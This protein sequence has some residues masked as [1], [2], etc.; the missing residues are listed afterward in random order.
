MRSGFSARDA[1]DRVFQQTVAPDHLK[2]VSSEMYLVTW[3]GRR[4][5]MYVTVPAF[6]PATSF[7]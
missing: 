1:Y 7:R 3:C 2:M 4:G 5:D 6:E